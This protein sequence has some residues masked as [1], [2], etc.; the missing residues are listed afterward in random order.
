VVALLC[1][2]AVAATAQESPAARQAAALAA[3]GRGDS[4]R[5]LLNRVLASTRAG[6][7]A[8]V[9][10]LYWR[11]RLAASGDSA[12]HDMRRVAIEFSSSPW[13]DDALLQLSHLALAAANPAAGYD[14]A[15][16]LRSD[17]PGSGLRPQA[18]LAAARA[19]FE[20]GE[21]RAACALLDSARAEAAADIEFGNQVLYYRARCR[22]GR[23]VAPAVA[24]AVTPDTARP[25]ATPGGSTVHGR[26]ASF[27]VQVLAARTDAAAEQAVQR[28]GQAGLRARIVRG[29]DGL[30]RVRL[31]PFGSIEEASAAAQAARRAVGGEPLVVRNP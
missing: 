6:E 11:G 29:D 26:R 4:A 17:Y 27:D 12:E 2:G 10:A 16:R 19:A 7:P 31:G 13:A 5:G 24:R 20:T 14:M 22:E 28:L 15:M 18:A 1:G 25:A 3:E 9:E 8:Y 23:P 30:R 21:P